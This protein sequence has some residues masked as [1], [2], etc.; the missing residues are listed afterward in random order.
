MS[1]SPYWDDTAIFVVEDDAQ[2]GADHVDAH[3][4]IA[5]VIS[6]YSPRSNAPFIDHHFYT[7]VSMVHTMENLLGLPPM[8]LFDA[9]APPLAPLFA[10]P[11][12]QPP[13]EADDKS[14]RSGLLYLMNDKKAPGA[15]KSAAMNFSRPDAVNAQELNAILWQDA[16][17]SAET[18]SILK[19][20]VDD[21]RSNAMTAGLLAV[22]SRKGSRTKTSASLSKAWFLA[23]RICTGTF[24]SPQSERC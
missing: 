22:R 12:T 18:P 2:D 6:K 5:L 4:S 20:R 1:H 19:W 13:Y 11:G 3:R 8:N 21:E 15:K 16:K 7:T 23:Q 9:H 17:G 14:L 24:R 10:G